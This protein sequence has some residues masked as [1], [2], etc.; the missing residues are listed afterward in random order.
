MGGNG[1]RKSVVSIESE[2][3]PLTI[4]RH[5]GHFLPETRPCHAITMRQEGMRFD[6]RRRLP[7][8][9]FPV[10]VAVRPCLSSFER[11]NSFLDMHLDSFMDIV[12]SQASWRVRADR[13][14]QLSTRNIDAA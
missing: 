11:R 10:F 9:L 1:S 14:E 8:T 5:F 13:N 7:S 2:F 6:A 12:V 3:I 4:A